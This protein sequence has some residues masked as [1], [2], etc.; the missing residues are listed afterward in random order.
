MSLLVL[1]NSSEDGLVDTEA[2]SGRDQRQREV[3][4][5]AGGI[6]ILSEVSKRSIEDKYKLVDGH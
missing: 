6:S 5:H 1:V 4:N 3:S 2:H